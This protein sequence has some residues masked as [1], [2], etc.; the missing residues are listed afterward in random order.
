MISHFRYHFEALAAEYRHFW[1]APVFYLTLITSL[2]FFVVHFAGDA[3]NTLLEFQKS[4]IY[5]QAWWRILGGNFTHFGLYHTV[6]NSA[7]FFATMLILFWHLSW[8][9]S[10]VSVLVICVGVGCGLLISDVDVYRGFSGANY[11]LLAFGLFAGLRKNMGVYG[12]ALLILTSK[13]VMEHTPNYDVNYLRDEIG[14]AVAV[15]AHLSG[16]I[17]GV[18]LGLLELVRQWRQDPI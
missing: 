18:G 13:M 9:K 6:M 10:L 11:G 16:F 3:I 8:Q 7:G 2:I 1:R 14:V 12:V 15:E 5:N 17:T 4:A